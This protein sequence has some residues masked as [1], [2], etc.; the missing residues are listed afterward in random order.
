M[1]CTLCNAAFNVMPCKG[2]KQNLVD[3][4]LF[5]V[6]KANTFHEKTFNIRWELLRKKCPC[7]QCLVKGICLELCRAYVDNIILLSD[8]IQR[9]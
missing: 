6:V 5:Q 3:R 7:S 8:R 2:K 4:F 9:E 1:P